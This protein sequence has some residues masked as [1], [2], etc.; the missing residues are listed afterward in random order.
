MI[1]QLIAIRIRALLAAANGKNK[2]GG[3]T[4]SG[5]KLALFIGL[6]AL[7]ALIFAGL[8][9]MTSFGM[10]FIMLPLGQ[11]AMYF[12]MLMTVTFAVVFFFSVFETKS[13]LFDCRDNELLLSMPIKPRDII[14]SRIFTVLALN[15]IVTLIVMLPAVVIYG[16]M[17]GSIMG[18][19]GGTLVI[20][21]LPLPIAALSSGVGYVVAVISK[22]LKNNSVLTALVSL[23]LVAVFYAGYFA[24]LNPEDEMIGESIAAMAVNPFMQAVGSAALLDPLAASIFVLSSVVISLVA[25]KIISIGYFSLLSSRATGKKQVYRSKRVEKRGAVIAV[26]IKD[27]RRLVSSAMLML[28]GCAGVMLSLLLC[29]GLIFAGAELEAFSEA[30]APLGNVLPVLLAGSLVLTGGMNTLSSCL[31][32][33]EGQ[34]LWILRSSPVRARDVLF[35]KALAH[36]V[37]SAPFSLIAAVAVIACSGAQILE[38]PL[39]LLITLVS[40]VFFALLGICF[41]VA[42]PKFDFDNEMQPVKQSMPVF[43]MMLAAT[44]IGLACSGGGMAL[45]VISSP[46]IA[47]L[48]MLLLL[49]VLC[50][51][52]FLLVVGPCTRRF[53]KF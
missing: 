6:Y 26:A 53:D 17:G 15:Y 13:E 48:S 50:A 11:D 42:F 16:F 46:L 40:N 44:L 3:G 22:K 2:R 25:Y 51:V 27:L 41:N 10:A 30:L 5:A 21:L 24:L 37:V 9:A 47:L 34:S 31:L 19:L 28:N 23:L 49:L 45:C 38:I 4:L 8:F 32:S 14:L 29:G 18:I 12:G 20:L 52:A 33:L 1:K 43:F 36:F 7:L 39:I 35:G